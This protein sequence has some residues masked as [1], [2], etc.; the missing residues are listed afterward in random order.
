M[1]LIP[2]VNLLGVW[3]S[4]LRFDAT[5]DLIMETIKL[6]DHIAVSPS[7]VYTVMQGYERDDVRAALNA[8]LATP[9]GMPVVWTLQWMGHDVERVYGPDVMQA[10][11]AR[12]A[13]ERWRHYFYGSAP[14]VIEKLIESLKIHY[15][16]LQVAGF[17]SPPFRELT[18]S[19]DDESIRRINASGAHIVWVGLGSP[20]QDLWMATHRARLDAPVLV[21]VG[22]AFDFFAGRIK[23]APRWV[24]RSGLEWLYRLAKEPSRLWPRYLIY[25]PKFILRVAQERWRSTRVR[26]DG[27][28][29]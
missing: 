18:P 12:S 26:R 27:D 28:K 17:D 15:P 7:P 11:C 4:T 29:Q 8:N 9:D 16:H 6:N 3:I 22:A 5:I 14:D 19:E 20:K 24:Q 13:H 10:V 1:P 25:N 21:G 2:R 23:Q